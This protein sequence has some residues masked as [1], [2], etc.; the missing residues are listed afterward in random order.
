M[1]AMPSVWVWLNPGRAPG[2]WVRANG[3]SNPRG[4]NQEDDN[5]AIV[6]FEPGRPSSNDAAPAAY[7][8]PDATFP[9]SPAGPGM[10]TPAHAGNAQDVGAG[11]AGRGAHGAFGFFGSL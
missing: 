1:A 7:T 9:A 4:P 10:R 6:E 5:P 2:G 11:G 8:E 3:E